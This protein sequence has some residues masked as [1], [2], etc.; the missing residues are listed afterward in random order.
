VSVSFPQATLGDRITI[1]VLGTKEDDE[2][3]AEPTQEVDL[4]PGTQPGDTVILRGQG[5]PRV[6]GRGTGDL[7]AH[8]K[9]VVP[10]SLTPE[11]EAHLRAYA[12]AGGQRVTPEKTGFF[13]RKKK[14]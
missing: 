14:K 5:L 7:I 12:A 13:K 8:V 10:T 9:V 2:S 1:P 4:A 3:G 6:D 11:E